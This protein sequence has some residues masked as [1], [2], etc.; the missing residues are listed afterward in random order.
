MKVEER[1]E[2]ARRRET[3]RSRFFFLRAKSE[4]KDGEVTALCFVGMPRKYNAQHF[5]SYRI[6]DYLPA[7][8]VTRVALSRSK[9]TSQ[10]VVGR[11]VHP[12]PV[13]PSAHPDASEHPDR[14]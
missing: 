4:E 13:D 9:K 11:R 2:N 1:Q 14:T 8:E 5:Y 7:L 12:V 3:E 6:R 10:N